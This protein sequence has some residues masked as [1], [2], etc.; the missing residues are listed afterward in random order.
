MTTGDLVKLKNTDVMGIIT[1]FQYRGFDHRGRLKLCRVSIPSTNEA[2]WVFDYD[3][4]K[5]Q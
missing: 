1:N 5:V 4:E 2:V 3:L